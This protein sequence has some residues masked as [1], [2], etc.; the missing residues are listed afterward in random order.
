MVS[1][2]C[3]LFFVELG[4]ICNSMSASL[5]KVVVD[6]NLQVRVVFLKSL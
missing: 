1:H 4:P 5:C 6:S 3:F 2:I